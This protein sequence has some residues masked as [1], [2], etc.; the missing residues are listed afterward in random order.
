MELFNLVLIPILIST[1]ISYFSTPLV[2]RFAKKYKLDALVAIG[3]IVKG[4]TKHDEYLAYATASGLMRISLDL[5]IP[6]G[7][8]VITVNNLSQARARSRGESN[9]GTEAVA[10]ALTAALEAR[11]R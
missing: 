11:R 10:A 3:C 4:E 9:K 8:G 1:L 7:F 6:V 2:I 5:G